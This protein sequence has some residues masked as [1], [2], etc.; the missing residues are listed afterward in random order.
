M[1]I[2]MKFIFDLILM[3]ISSAIMYIAAQILYRN[4]QK[5]NARWYYAMLVT[6]MLILI[7]PL[8]WLFNIPKM[9]EVSV[10]E[11]IITTAPVKIPV[12]ITVSGLVIAIWLAVA[13]VSAILVIIKHLKTRGALTALS[14]STYNEDILRAY[15]EVSERIGI[16]RRIDVRTSCELSSPLMFGIIKPV[17][18]IPYKDF[19]YSELVMI[20]SHEL[21]HYRHKD[22]LIKFISSISVCIH[23]FNP[24]AYLLSKSLNSACELCC[25]E[26]VLGML[27]LKDKKEY[28]RLIISVIESS[29]DKRLSYTT[30]MA[31]TESGIKRRLRKIAQFSR[32]SMA[33]Q[34]VSVML[35]VSVFVTSLTAF[36]VDFV[37]TVLPDNAV[38][39]IEKIE[40]TPII[41][42]VPT[43]VPTPAPTQ[44]VRQEQGNAH[45]NVVIPDAIQQPAA[46]EIV[47]PT[48]TPRPG[49]AVT[50]PTKTPSEP[51]R[52]SSVNIEINDSVNFDG[53]H[54]TNNNKKQ[55]EANAADKIKDGETVKAYIRVNNDGSYDLMHID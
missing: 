23:W 2:I 39:M 14:E 13:V 10:P 44:E 12:G 42:S 53:E 33:M 55:I 32:P 43:F 35:V 8:Q 50:E 46:V 54:I 26:S 37:K 4:M 38:E 41:D 49:Q 52:N 21:M 47:E 5:K 15:N 36:G 25:D 28:G 40:D 19:S 3:G 18:V 9:M 7:L 22:L 45:S 30:A 24:V 6:S 31:S 48:S 29:L 17:V 16:H 27:E 51:E 34:I 20:M 1:V 11:E